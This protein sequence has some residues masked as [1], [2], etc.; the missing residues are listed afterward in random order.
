MK[1]TPHSGH[2]MPCWTDTSKLAKITD[3]MQAQNYDSWS[4]ANTRNESV[5]G[6][7]N[8]G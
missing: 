2:I 7:V 3:M 4:L 8:V 5:F 6:F 1:I